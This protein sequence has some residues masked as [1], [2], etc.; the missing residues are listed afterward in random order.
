MAT[1]PIWDCWSLFKQESSR[2]P[3]LNTHVTLELPS[4]GSLPPWI[5]YPDLLSGSHVLA[6]LLGRWQLLFPTSVPIL[7]LLLYLLSFLLPL[8]TH[9]CP[10][11]FW[12]PSVSLSAP[13]SPEGLERSEVHG[14]WYM[15]Q[16]MWMY[17][18]WRVTP[19]LPLAAENLEIKGGNWSGQSGALFRAWSGK[20]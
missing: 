20:D 4:L 16:P 5:H 14:T 18:C 15:V 2:I 11:H 13:T 19:K 17:L 12:Q 1:V 8:P 6:S 3:I 7:L 9:S 10:V